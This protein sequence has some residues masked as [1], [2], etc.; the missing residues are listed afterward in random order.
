MVLDF[1]LDRHGG[2]VDAAGVASDRIYAIGAAR[3]GTRWEAAAIPEIRRHAWDLAA[4]LL[5]RAAATEASG[6]LLGARRLA[7][8]REA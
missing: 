2:L 4:Q 5:G 1:D 6:E 3:R 7:A 8:A